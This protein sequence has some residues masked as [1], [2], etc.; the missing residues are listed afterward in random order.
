MKKK[1]MLRRNKLNI[2]DIAHRVGISETLCTILVNREIY[3]LQDI[4]GFLN[5]SLEK[6]HNPLLMKDMDKG[7]EIIKKAIMD[8]KKI[9]IYGDYDAGATRS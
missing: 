7:T 8:K 2:K 3:N 4:E 6:L 9:A 5:S 1:W